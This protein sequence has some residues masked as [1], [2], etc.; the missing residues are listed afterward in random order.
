[1]I[2]DEVHY[3]NDAE[4]GVV[5]EEVR[6]RVRIG[7]RVRVRVRVRIGFRDSDWA[8]MQSKECCGERLGLGL[9]LGVGLELEL[10]LIS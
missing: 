8:I 7:V 5:W 9:G 4:R 10:G 2:F 3:V 1:V 6:I